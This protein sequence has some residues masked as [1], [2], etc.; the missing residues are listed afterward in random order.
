VEVRRLYGRRA[1]IEE[2]IR[3]GKHQRGFSGGQARSER[4]Q[5]QHI[6]CCLVAFWVLER[7]GHD[8]PLTIYQLK[9]QLSFQGDS[10]ALPALERLRQTA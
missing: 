4:A 10:R 7:E 1:Q 2:V 6:A 3:V 5:Q 9:R 8:R